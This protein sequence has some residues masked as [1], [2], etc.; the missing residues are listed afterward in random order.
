VHW[1]PTIGDPLP[2]VDAAWFEPVKWEAWI[3][4]PR[5]HGQDWER[6][7]KA[8]MADDRRL[9]TAIRAELWNAPVTALRDLGSRGVLC[10]V[11]MRVSIGSR[12]T[13]TVTAWHYATDQSDPRLVTAYP[14]T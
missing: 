8:G 10:E 6:V 4:D 1:P 12:T 3:L 7:L 2:R 13:Q 5:G 14:V 9:W 11:Q